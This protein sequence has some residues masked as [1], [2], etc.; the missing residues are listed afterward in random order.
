MNNSMVFGSSYKSD[1]DS[2]NSDIVRRA[3]NREDYLCERIDKEQGRSDKQG[4]S[5]QHMGNMGKLVI[6]AFARL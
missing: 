2:K 6:E 1:R 5:T 4:Q 3:R